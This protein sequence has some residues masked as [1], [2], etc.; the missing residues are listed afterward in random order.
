[1]PNKSYPVSFLNERHTT[2]E[3]RFPTDDPE[4]LFEA[5]NAY[6]EVLADPDLI[7]LEIKIIGK[8]KNDSV[9]LED[10]TM[11]RYDDGTTEING[12]GYVFEPRSP[13]AS[14]DLYNHLSDC[15][16]TQVNTIEGEQYV[17]IA[18]DEGEGQTITLNKSTVEEVLSTEE[19]VNN[20]G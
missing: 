10:C 3:D 13:Q 7:C 11:R 8:Y 2:V 1:M 19:S 17:D 16:R 6:T 15:L 14:F 9:L 4:T 18:N 20:Y 12:G 5:L